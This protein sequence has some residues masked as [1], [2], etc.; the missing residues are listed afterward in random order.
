MHHRDL[1]RDDAERVAIGRRRGDRRMADHAGAA[2]AV[3]DVEGRLRS[4]SST[5]ATMRAVASVPPPAP[6]GQIDWISR[7]RRVV[8]LRQCRPGLEAGGGRGGGGRR[9]EAAPRERSHVFPPWGAPAFSPAFEMPPRLKDRG[10]GATIGCGRDPPPS[11]ATGEGALGPC[12]STAYRRSPFSSA[13]AG[14]EPASDCTTGSN[15]AIGVS[16]QERHARLGPGAS[17]RDRTSRSAVTSVNCRAT[18][19]AR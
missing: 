1:D 12:P 13:D 7:P 6:H 4:F 2:G 10:S 19:S 9:D 17:A 11:L 5:A 18:A 8:R 14:E 15:A 16:G 3:D